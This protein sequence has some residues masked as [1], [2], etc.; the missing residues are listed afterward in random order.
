MKMLQTIPVKIAIRPIQDASESLWCAELMASLDTWKKLKRDLDLTKKVFENAEKEKYLISIKNQPIGFLVIDMKGAFRGYIQ[1]I[2]LVPEFQGKGLGSQIITFAESRIFE[3]S[4]NV[5]MCVSSFNLKAKA[6]YDRLGF[7]TIGIL[8]DY[9]VK[10]H[11]EYLLRKSLGPV[12]DFK[13]K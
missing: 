5:F 11:D 8:K 6:L 3:E 12:S 9:V 2:G 7:E 1:S 13:I 4:A 10:G